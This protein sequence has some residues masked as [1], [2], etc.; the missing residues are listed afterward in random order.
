M[1]SVLL[2]SS[3]ELFNMD[4]IKMDDFLELILRFIFNFVV[5]FVIVRRIYYPRTHRRDFFF[6]FVLISS[7]VFLMCFLLES[8]K[9]QLGFALGLFAV[10]GIIRYR[11]TT[12]PIKEM[13]YLFIVIGISVINA[14]AN[15]KI[16]Y[17]ELVF[18]NAAVLVLSFFVE[19]LKTLEPE[20]FAIV[21]YEKIE[22]VTPGK[23]KELISDLE[24]KLGVKISRI[25][26]SNVDYIR[27][28]AKIHVYFL[29]SQQKWAKDEEIDFRITTDE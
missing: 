26:I 10:F 4:I 11:T 18:A 8:V 5:T 1:I 6:T 19:R 13:T 12:I 22:L 25:E 9:L 28:T 14:L 23:K 15:K 20:S 24:N 17:A 21:M 3:V 16:S 7:V 27:D 29:K 2:D